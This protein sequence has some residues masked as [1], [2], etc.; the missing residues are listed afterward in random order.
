MKN[1]SIMIKPA[2]SL[3]NLRC[4]YCFYEDVSAKRETPCCGMMTEETVKHM[5]ENIAADLMPGDGVH[6][7]FQ[8]GEPTLAGIPFFERFVDSGKD[9]M[10]GIRISYA[11]QTNGILLDDDWCRFLKEH[12]FLVGI[13][14]DILP[15]YHNAARVDCENRETYRKVLEKIRL[16]ERYGVD[17][18]ILCTL[19]NAIARHPK[20]VW[21]WLVKV[22]ISYVQFT[23]CLGESDA[24]TESPYALTPER[25]AS[26]Y[27]QLFSYWYADYQKGQY[28]SVKFFDDAVNLLMYGRPTSCGMNGTCQPQLVI[29]ADGSA[30]PCDFYCLDEYRMGHITEQGPL[31]L[32]RSTAVQS[33]LNRP[34][35]SPKL[36][37]TCRYAVFCGGNCK[38]MQKEI[39]C[40]AD[41]TYCGYRDFLEECGKALLE[42][43]DRHRKR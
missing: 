19:T 39:C 11:L 10:S 32:L 8:G 15:E 18:N 23:P 4:K 27:K 35:P 25:F 30:Y 3:C 41:D 36:C 17:Y 42:I 9:A 21:N 26:F 16:L 20:Q 33:F 38:R 40:K 22:Q 31:E 1:L 13:S 28:R 6:F 29:E 2:S 12:R 5:M 14:L 34:H 37:E 24:E 7:V 43:A